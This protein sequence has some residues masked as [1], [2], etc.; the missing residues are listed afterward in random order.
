MV[1][2]LS[3]KIRRGIKQVLDSTTLD[4]KAIEAGKAAR[5]ALAK[6]GVKAKAAVHKATAPKEE[7]PDEGVDR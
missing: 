7:K 2:K 5:E 4:E 1:G 6:G 3:E